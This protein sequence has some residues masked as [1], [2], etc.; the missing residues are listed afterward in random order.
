MHIPLKISLPLLLI[1]PTAVWFWGTQKYDFLTPRDIPEH[2]LRP[3]FA[4]PVNSD[5]VASLHKLRQPKEEPKPP[6]IPDLDPGDLLTPPSLS[7][8]QQYAEQGAPAIL[9]LAEKLQNEGRIQRAALAYE[10]IID[11][12]P[13]TSIE[14]EQAEVTLE[15]L[16]TTLPLWNIEPNEAVPLTINIVTARSE[17]SLQPSL[18]AISELIAVSSGGLCRPNFALQV[19]PTPSEELPALPIVLWL[20]V[21][22]EDLEAPSLPVLTI[23]PSA[24]TE[25]DSRLA[26]SIYRLLARRIEENR[27]LTTPPPLL[28]TEN[29]ET[30]LVA[31]ITRLSWNQL[32][33]TPLQVF[34]LVSKKPVLPQSPDETA[35]T[36]ENNSESEEE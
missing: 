11:S 13:V 7:E 20:T 32:L 26:F 34:E 3:E 36:S 35:P 22:G 31:K 2:E 4:S 27:A 9:K 8:Y 24:D 33:K 1:A 6:P 12:T 29:P 30:E 18:A 17:D 23:A 10:R 19:S 21:A 28:Q 25:L 15:A 14:R 16:K 5:I